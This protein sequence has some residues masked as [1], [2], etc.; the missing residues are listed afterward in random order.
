[1]VTMTDR[2]LVTVYWSRDPH[3]LEAVAELLTHAGV[4]VHRATPVS[5]SLFG[6][7]VLDEGRLDVP[8]D[9]EEVAHAA[10]SAHFGEPEG[11]FDED[12]SW[13]DELAAETLRLRPLLAA[14]MALFC[15]SHFYARRVVTGAF[16]WMGQALAFW[17][18]TRGSWEEGAVGSLLALAILLYDFVGGQL[19]VRAYN[20][21]H[22]RG[23]GAQM[24]TGALVLLG[25]GTLASFV[26]PPLAAR[27][28]LRHP[29][30]HGGHGPSDT[31]EYRRATTAPHRLPFPFH[32]DF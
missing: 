1:M 17:T 2:R 16:L 6:G 29:G 11:L 15:A 27:T 10:L 30:A 32:L 23:R 31:A 26:G 21:G 12:D 3:E 7:A 19:A 25:L 20:R 13:K 28:R 24:L 4:P 14:G 5:S 8:E 9:Q 18:M 22:R